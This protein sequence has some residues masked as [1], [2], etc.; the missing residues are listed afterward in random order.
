MAFMLPLFVFEAWRMASRVVAAETD[1]APPEAGASGSLN[2]RAGKRDVRKRI[3]RP[4]L[5]FAAPIVCF[6]IAG[7]IFNYVRFGSLT[8]FGHSYLDVRQ[9]LQIE[10]YGLA[11][12]HYLGRNLAVAFTLLPDFLP[13]APWVQIGGHGLAMWVTTPLLL[14]V[15]WP[16]EK[17][18]IHRALWL[19]VA[20]V[21]LPS[22]FY[23]NSGWFQFGYRFSL[24]YIV[25][26]VMLIA[27]GGRPLRGFAKT[28]IV[29]GIVINLFGAVTFDRYW[30]F[31][32][33][34]GNAYDVVVAH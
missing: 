29:V 2:L 22:L 15:V 17:N 12:H 3:V 34:G 21:A 20:A 13:R 33:G 7:M 30:Q 14:F 4:L 19:T 11:S 5:Q 6:A 32:R 27:I 31:Y 18:V 8:E 10:K 24:D 25:F 26:L 16:R 23:Q 1:S 28:L 9:Q